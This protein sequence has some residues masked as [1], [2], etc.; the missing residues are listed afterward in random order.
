MSPIFPFQLKTS[1]PLPIGYPENIVTI[2][3]HIRVKRLKLGL[4]IID[5]AKR[6]GVT[7]DTVLNWEHNSHEAPVRYMPKIISFLVY[8]PFKRE[9]HVNVPTKSGLTVKM[10][11]RI[12][13]SYL[14]RF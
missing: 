14:K 9:A 2:G 3:D 8:V 4:R 11:A 5:V 6:V 12:A 10:P 13:S 7:A 1:K